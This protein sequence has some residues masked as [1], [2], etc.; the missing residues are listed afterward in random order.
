MQRRDFLL[1]AA[2]SAAG[3]ALN[4]AAEPKTDEARA[5]AHLK[6][7]MPP[8]QN[9]ENFL[10]GRQGPEKLSKNSGWVFDA[11]LGWLLCDSVR[12]M[13]VNKSRGFYRYDSDGARHVVNFAD[14]PCRIHT[15]GD[16]FTHC[17]QVSDGETWQEYLAAHLQ[18][19]VRN[20]GIGG[21]S[22]YQAYRRMLR[23]EKQ[24]PARYLILNIFDDDH[25]R[26]L[27]AWRSIRFGKDS[28]AGFTLPHLKVNLGKKTCTP[29][30]NLLQKPED[31]YKLCDEEWV[32]KTFKDDPILHKLL[33]ASSKETL[34]R[35]LLQPVPVQVGLPA[36]KLAA[37]EAA[38]KIA[39][40][41][42]AEALFATQNVLT[43]IEQHIQRTGQKFLLILSFSKRAVIERLEGKP[44][45]DQT[46]IDWLK[47][48]PYP[49]ID[50]REKFQAE[51]KQ[52]KVEPKTYLDRYYIGHLTP[53]GNFFS[54]W[55][56]MKELVAWLDPK[57]LPYRK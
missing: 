45:F 54:A 21:Y 32:W 3:A 26:N 42:T 6:S 25:F 34:S 35:Q 50:M 31:V 17:D 44:R 40:Q 57:P 43:W 38:R 1:A 37:S 51:F 20:F 11:E 36:E 28:K 8:R 56:I 23:V 16:S 14:R 27:D 53:A 19:P 29:V 10:K 4:R 9:V 33:A 39:L 22:V 18:E 5:R 15:F 49:V 52:M 12:P 41:H 24:K 55:A 30:V 13:S 46:F 48:K 2:A 47:D 7:I